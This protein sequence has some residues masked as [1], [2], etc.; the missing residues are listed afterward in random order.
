MAKC[1]GVSGCSCRVTAGPGVTVD[2]NGSAANPYVVSASGGGTTA[3]EVTDSPSVDLTL[4]GTGAPAD[5][6]QVSATVILDPSPPVNGTNLMHSGPDGL[7]L[8]CADVRGCISA[9]DGIAYDQ[10]SGEIAA[11][12]ST[13]AGNSVTFGTD[14]G[15]YAPTGGGG[16]GT[17]V[18]AGDTPTADTTVS[19]TGTAGDPYVVSTD[20]IV[21]PTPPAGG[22][23]LLQAGPD[24]LYVEC[25][26]V[27]GCISAGDGIGY[28]PGT[29]E[30]A[31]K[32]STDAGNQTVFG[33]DGGLYTPAMPTALQA[34]DTPTVDVTVTGTGTA[35]DPYQV[36][37]NVIL[38]PTPP[39]GGTNL[40]QE[41]PGG[42]FVEC[43]DVRGC[44]SAGDGIDYDPG[45]GEIAAKLSTDAGNQTVFG[46]DGGLY[47]PAAPGTALQAADT[48]T[49]DTT[50]TG[51]GTAG[52]PYVV[53]SD[54][55]VAPEPN[56][57]EATAS[58]LLVAPSG[59]A[60]NQ[61]S[62]GGDGR[63]FVPPDAPLEIGCGLQGDGTAATPLEA[64]TKAGT[65]QWSAAWACGAATHST[66]K[67]DP[68]DGSLWTPPEHYSAAEAIYVE[69]FVGGWATPLTTAP[70]KIISNGANFQFNFPSN[71]L[72]NDC[73][74]WSYDACAASTWDIN[75]TATAVFELGYI[76]SWGGGA[77]IIRPLWG[78]LTAP[79][80]ARRERDGGTFH[81][82]GFNMDPLAAHSLVG[83]P[84]IRVQ[85]GSVTIN[86][87]IT[88]AAYHTTTQ[89]N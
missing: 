60:G 67:C 62:I 12:P 26:D 39:Q 48:N 1:C 31:A 20:V 35:G 41:G 61:L 51:S 28:D 68:A 21:D 81:E 70:W 52:D 83:W 25:A 82:Y 71:F 15:L 7:Y 37:A 85:A 9:G 88:D 74:R 57:L 10:A 54:A 32:L 44:I 65:G 75:Y 47:T 76:Y 16:G 69:H 13:D 42:L 89:N 80:T 5:P 77:G 72:G 45:T 66:L 58:G 78:L 8:E 59:D 27:R 24:G 18:Q 3:L 6:Y 11:R 56:G 46:S 17:I 33:S 86:S 19:G 49:V 73:R 43:A 2:G 29:G 4:A 14:G 50:V 40:I 36:A 87:W 30:I 23:N 63:L 34:V 22:T 84:A 64:K 38:D 55:I 53:K 79:G